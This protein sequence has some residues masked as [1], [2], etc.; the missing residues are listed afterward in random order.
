MQY[1]QLKLFIN[2]QWLDAG[3]GG[4]RDLN[5]PLDESLLTQIP[6]AGPVELNLA[7]ESVHRGF[8]IWKKKNAHERYIILRKA[9]D[10]MRERSKEIGEVLTMEQGKPLN[11]SIREITLAADITDFQAEEAK[12]LY[13]RDVPTRLPNII[14]QNVIRQPIG[15]VAAFAPWNFPVNLTVRKMASALAAGCSVIVR[16]DIQTPGCA[17]LVVQCFLDAGVPADALNFVIGKPSE[18][19]DVL[20]NN[21]LIRKVSF[22][23]SVPIGKVL[24]EQCARL[25]KH[26]TSELGGHSAVIVCE[27]ADI[28][29]TI[30]ASVTGKFRNAGQICTC[31]TRWFIHE[32][33]FDAWVAEFVEKTKQI[34]LGSGMDKD[35]E[36]GPLAMKRRLETMQELVDDAV[37]KGA[38]V[39]TGGHRVGDKGWFFAPTVV[40]NVPADARLAYDE[41]FGPIAIVEK[42][43]DLNEAIEK[44]NSL[45]Y[46]LAAYAFTTDA[47]KQHVLGQELEA[48]MVGINHFGVSQPETPFGGWKESGIGQEMGAEGI[49][50]YTEVKLIS[51]STPNGKPL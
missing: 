34:K 20:I 24:G 41:P 19:S 45:P 16:P 8:A 48:G 31:P 33:K 18:V 3:S 26:F 5:S 36:M 17:M 9:A 21:P 1:P 37:A 22:T 42:Y 32:S 25:V 46:A 38:T 13:G 51:V 27:D 7:A 50:P 2:G 49:L 15:P 35:T 10:L 40:T 6:L 29:Y 30:A 4:T 12:R 44:A 28:P 11:E 23:G 47:M 14:S 43:S 39:L